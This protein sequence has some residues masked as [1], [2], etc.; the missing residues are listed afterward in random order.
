MSP[1]ILDFFLH[2]FEMVTQLRGVLRV[3]LECERF[4]DFDSAFSVPSHRATWAPHVRREEN[5]I[6]SRPRTPRVCQWV[7]LF[8]LNPTRFP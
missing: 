8:D 3:D 2:R 6:F 1:C 5:A 7:S 4:R